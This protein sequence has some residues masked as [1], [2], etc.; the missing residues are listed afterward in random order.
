MR[1]AAFDY[2]L[3]PERIAQRPLPKR[4][5]SRLLLVSRRTGACEDRRFRDL[6]ALLQGDE[7][8]VLNNARVFPARLWARRQ[9]VHARPLGRHSP[10][11]GEHLTAPIEVLLLGRLVAEDTWEALV[12]P[13]RKVRTG[14]VLVFG[15][16][17]LE[18]EVL[19]RGD[20]GRRTLRFRAAGEVRKVMERLGHVPLPPYIDRPD[21]AADR[22]RYQ[23]VFARQGT[24]VAAP[25]AG[26]H[27][28]PQT[29]EAV[30]QRGCDVV[31]LTLEVGYGTFQPIRT[32]TVERHK[33]HPEGYDIPAGA[34]A[35]IER[36][37]AA[38][39]PVLAVGTSVVRALEDSA[40][41]HGRVVAGRAEASLYIYPGHAFKAVNQLLTNFH[42]PRSSLLLLVCAF[43]GRETVLRAYGHAVA[44]SY[45]FYSYGDCMLIR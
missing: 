27:F 14:E 1:L 10:I 28:T 3:P 7:L 36:A 45:R 12:R 42:L 24:A 31:E 5:A 40:A 32:E 35:A 16:G 2:V 34:A 37:Q 33:M 4:D 44:E 18:A 43:A 41:R 39:R 25:T 13:G 6:A 23:T 17:E 38:G 19:G 21:E 22:E 11:R 30:R 8:V 26:L 15:E 9:G 29:L 20:Y